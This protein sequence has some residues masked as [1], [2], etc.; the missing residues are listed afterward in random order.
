M[1]L[2][3][4]LCSIVFY[5][6]PP[7]AL[8]FYILLGVA[9]FIW[10]LKRNKIKVTYWHLW[11]VLPPLLLLLI[12]LIKLGYLSTPQNV[13]AYYMTSI[14]DYLKTH[15]P[16]HIPDW[17]Y[18]HPHLYMVSERL[19]YGL[20][21]GS[22][23]L[24]SAISN[25]FY[26]P[27]WKIYY[28]L[29]CS[30]ALYPALLFVLIKD[31]NKPLAWFSYALAVT[32]ITYL[33]WPIDGQLP[34]IL[35]MMYLT[36]TFFLGPGSVFTLCF[37]A[38][39][40]CYPPLIPYGLIGPAVKSFFNPSLIKRYGLCVLVALVISPYMSVFLIKNAS[41]NYQLA[42]KD[43]EN[44]P[45]IAN[46]S[47]LIGLS[48]H[49]S[50]T[51]LGLRIISWLSIPLVITGSISALTDKHLRFIPVSL[52]ICAFFGAIF[53]FFMKYEYAFYKHSVVTFF[54]FFI[55]F[56]HGIALFYRKNR[57]LAILCLIIF[58]GLQCRASN[59]F[60]NSPWTEK[61][62][63]S[64]EEVSF[65]QKVNAQKEIDGI[66]LILPHTVREEAWAAYFLK[67]KK[68]SIYPMTLP[69]KWWPFSSVKGIGPIK[70]FFH[71][72]SDYMLSHPLMAQG[73]EILEQSNWV[74]LS[75]P[76][77][78]LEGDVYN[79]E[80]YP[81]G[82]FRWSKSQLIIRTI[83]PF[84]NARLFLTFSPLKHYTLHIKVKEKE[85]FYK[86]KLGWQTLNIDLGTLQM[87]DRILIRIDNI[88][89]PIDLGINL[90]PRPLGIALKEFGLIER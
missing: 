39:A 3:I 23:L 77:C 1:V 44:I 75:K 45:D 51:S 42:L 47:Q 56:S 73:K 17:D 60:F 71:Q 53:L 64:P 76:I 86:A 90:D 4:A 49:F 13:Y 83:R 22:T 66:I 72:N 57:T 81:E 2:G 9:I 19:S 14:A 20:I 88:K 7:N 46:L 26:L 65:L 69:W 55:M 79:I 82:H 27:T 38:L 8:A 28:L 43:W 24:T 40:C 48:L 36:L 25:G 58:V 5:V 33:K 68:L 35:G 80:S 6:I 16:W 34:I 87:G 30:I 62:F 74:L 31:L 21:L 29:C 37:A 15:R 67:E 10:F 63:L 85:W 70:T 11:L 84:N 32:T 52:L 12:P 89:R 50:E 78:Y 41:N 18:Y 61:C 54:L 59:I